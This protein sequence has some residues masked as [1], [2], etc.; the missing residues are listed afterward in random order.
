MLR[1]IV[2]C[3]PCFLTHGRAPCVGSLPGLYVQILEEL[4]TKPRQM[5]Q[6][7]TAEGEKLAKISSP[8]PPVSNFTLNRKLII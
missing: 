3:H 7:G 4:E 2:K 6:Q 5:K 8:P 1:M